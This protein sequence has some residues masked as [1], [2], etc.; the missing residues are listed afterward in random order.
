MEVSFLKDAIYAV[1][2]HILELW[3]I[4]QQTTAKPKKK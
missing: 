4:N 2:P 3:A 1:M